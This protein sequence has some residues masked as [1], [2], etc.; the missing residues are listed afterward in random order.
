MP[1]AAR[2]PGRRRVAGHGRDPMLRPAPSPCRNWMPGRWHKL[3]QPSPDAVPASGYPERPSD[4]PLQRSAPRTRADAMGQI[5]SLP[6]LSLPATTTVDRA[7]C[8]ERLFWLNVGTVQPAR[9]R[10]RAAVPGRCHH[11]LRQRPLRYRVGAL[12]RHRP[13]VLPG[14]ACVP[15]PGPASTPGGGSQAGGARTRPPPGDISA[16]DGLPRSGT[17]Q[18][19][20]DGGR[21]TPGGA[22]VEGGNQEVALGSRL[23]RACQGPPD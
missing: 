19:R 1:T 16:G 4:R 2:S 5:R 12:L 20:R 10:R 6:T 21:D 11:Q 13:A 23:G 18:E 22:G 3:G 17:P 8:T 7:S 15:V 9:W 14:G